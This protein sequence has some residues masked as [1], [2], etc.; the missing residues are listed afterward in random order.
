MK[1]IPKL[2]R[3]AY[4]LLLCLLAVAVAVAAVAAADALEGRFAARIDLSFNSVTTQS[5][6]TAKA[7]QSLDKDVHAYVLATQGNTLTD[8]N[9]LLDR[10]QAATPRFTW[11]QES[12]SRNPLL[13]QWMSDD[14]SDSAVTG[15]CVIVRCADTGR[16]RVLT[17][18]DYMSFG[19]NPDSGAYEFTG[20]TY[21]KAL[22]E[23]ILYTAADEIPALQLLS[24]HGE[25]TAA[26]TAVLEK[27][28]TEA[29]Y[30]PLRVNLKNGDALDPAAPLLILS[31]TLDVDEGELSALTAFA[32]A[33]GSLLVTV[34]FTDPD[35]LPNLYAFY[36][37]YGV[38]P[39]PGLVVADEGD[40][41]GYYTSPIE[42]TPT[43]RSVEGVT[44]GLVQSGA[45]FL[46][47]A[48]ARALDL[49]GTQS[50]DLL[51]ELL[52]Q[53]GEGSYLRAAQGGSIDITRQAEDPEGP[54]TLAVLCDRGF[55]DGTRSRACFIGNSGMFLNDT[56]YNLTYSNE[57][58]Q[59]V[60]RALMGSSSIDL[61]IL[62]RAAARPV[63]AAQGSA[64]PVILLILPPLL[65][66]LLAVAIL[67][68]RK[69]L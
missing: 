52:L 60:L 24:G 3:R 14:V 28:L 34:D 25:L 1:K 56:L 36:R 50:A 45:N 41:S 67:T 23:A 8:L 29:N 64:V 68:P 7:L 12:L 38:Q 42:L 53:S 32:Q 57:L 19:Y 16:T 35:V 11:S 30:A 49:V 55:G 27:K 47:L 21:E 44:D 17:W 59:Q 48:P 2:R 66:A 37:L 13:L 22:T 31:P 15:D 39:L 10:Y 9:A 43:L 20:L 61:D 54:F 33:G 5:E 65:I 63:L 58:M 62:P 26:E 46:I 40:R 6:A 69:Y 4:N 51:M 18:E